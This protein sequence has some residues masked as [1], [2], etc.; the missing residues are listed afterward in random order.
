MLSVRLV[1]ERCERPTATVYYS[2]V[3]WSV[4]ARAA[5]GRVERVQWRAGVSPYQFMRQPVYK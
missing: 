5:D 2:G 4:V 1:T 3:E